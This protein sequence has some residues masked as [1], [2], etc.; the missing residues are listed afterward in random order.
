MNTL[1]KVKRMRE[2]TDQTDARYIRDREMY[3]QGRSG[4]LE[5]AENVKDQRDVDLFNMGLNAYYRLS[6]EV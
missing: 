4:H 5:Y 2:G 6:D 1:N 3:L